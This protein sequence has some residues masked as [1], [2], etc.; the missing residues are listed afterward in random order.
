MVP[1]K[2]LHCYG[3]GGALMPMT[4]QAKIFHEWVV[5]NFNPEMFQTNW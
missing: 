1:N 3:F 5:L 2:H 4:K